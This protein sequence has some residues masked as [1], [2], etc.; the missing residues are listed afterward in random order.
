MRGRNRIKNKRVQFSTVAKKTHQSLLL[1][2]IIASGVLFV[3][4]LFLMNHV[5]IKGV[6]ITEATK[7][8][9]ALKEK[10]EILEAQMARLQTQEFLGK[11][12]DKNN[13]VF[14]E[15]TSRFV[16]IPAERYTAQAPKN[17]NRIHP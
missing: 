13:L 15:Q 16:I 2:M 17:Q 3:V 12:S 1:M 14:R 7:E 9:I 10:S 4:H 11:A 8:N 6:V 5:M